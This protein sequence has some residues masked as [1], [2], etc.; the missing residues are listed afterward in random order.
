MC[1]LVIFSGACTRCGEEQTWE[2]LSQQLSCLEAKNNDAFGE[3]ERGVYSEQHQFDQ[4]C[5]RCAEEDEGLGDVEDEELIFTSASKRPAESD[6]TEG[7]HKKQKHTYGSWRWRRKKGKSGKDGSPTSSAP[8]SYGMAKAS[9]GE[10]V[11]RRV[12]EGQKEKSESPGR[13]HLSKALLCVYDTADEAL[14]CPRCLPQLSHNGSVSRGMNPGRGHECAAVASF[15]VGRRP[16]PAGKHRYER[17]VDLVLV[18][19]SRARIEQQDEPHEPGK[20]RLR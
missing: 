10:F 4:E 13:A 18:Q 11:D 17:A 12:K 15:D 1:R 2:H 7:E 3:C 16:R 19:V 8:L 9:D 20:R 5:D 6:G 14:A